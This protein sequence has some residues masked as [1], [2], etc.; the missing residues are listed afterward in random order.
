MLKWRTSTRLANNQ[1]R[2]DSL[3]RE[4][5]VLHYA[6][7]H[8]PNSGLPRSSQLG[9]LSVVKKAAHTIS[10]R[11]SRRLQALLPRG[12]VEQAVAVCLVGGCVVGDKA[13]LGRQTGWQDPCGSKY[14]QRFVHGMGASRAGEGYRHF[15]YL[16]PVSPTPA[17]SRR[18]RRFLCTSSSIF[19]TE[20]TSIFY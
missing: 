3:G 8:L 7:R 9:S 14:L 4:G 17:R 5:I 15:E 18:F 1:S 6:R 16:P 19:R 20:L 2:Q 13:L 10:D 11:G 12:C